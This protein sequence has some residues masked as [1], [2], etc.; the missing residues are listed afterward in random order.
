M[1]QKFLERKERR[2]STS[3]P[4]QHPYY[5]VWGM[6]GLGKTTLAQLVYNEK[7]AIIESIDGSSPDL[8]ELDPL[9]H[10]SNKTG[11]S[12]ACTDDVWDDYG[13]GGVN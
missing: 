3:S 12:F 8:Q 10:A 2:M 4:M 5:A 11:K 13:D 9:Q 7:G 6:G 1:N